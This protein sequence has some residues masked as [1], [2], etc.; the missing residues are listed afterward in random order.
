V[1]L[2]CARGGLVILLVGPRTDDGR[3]RRRCAR[4]VALDTVDRPR[5]E[6]AA[7]C[8]LMGGFFGI[9]LVRARHH[10]VAPGHRCAA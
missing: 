2:K 5:E 9:F 4:A 10:V 7:G 8:L 6:L 3:S 1:D